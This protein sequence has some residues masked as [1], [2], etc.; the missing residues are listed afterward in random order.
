MPSENFS[1]L[2]GPGRAY[3]TGFK[4]TV[5]PSVA[6]NQPQGVGSWCLPPGYKLW[7]CGPR[8]DDGEIENYGQDLGAQTV[9]ITASC[10][11]PTNLN[12]LVNTAIDW[13]QNF[14]RVR[15]G[16][17]EISNDVQI[18]DFD[19]LSCGSC[20]SVPAYDLIFEVYYPLV[21][22][23]AS[24]SSLDIFVSVAVGT[25]PSQGASS[26]ARKTVNIGTIAKTVTSSRFAIPQWAQGVILQ[27][28]NIPPA[29][30]TMMIEQDGDFNGTVVLARDTISKLEGSVVP[31]V[32]GA[33]FFNITNM[34]EEDDATGVRAIFYL[35][36]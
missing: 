31:I 12:G 27:N 10:A 6:G 25:R 8:R 22:A 5:V 4:F 28:T 36:L 35:C 1:R 7:A 13:S 2:V 9:H 20:I 18:C 14:M 23:D 32:N 16:S 21:N 33:R 19:L 30:D 24:P 3:H 29:N 17:G 15:W 26:P 11:L 34:S